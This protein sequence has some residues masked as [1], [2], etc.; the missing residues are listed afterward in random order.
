MRKSGRKLCRCGSFVM[1]V[2]LSAAMLLSL[3]GYASAETMSTVAEVAYERF[4]TS[5]ITAANAH[6]TTN[7]K[8]SVT[9]TAGKDDPVASMKFTPVKA[10]TAANALRVVIANRASCRVAAFDYVYKN[11]AQI[12][13]RGRVE[14]SLKQGEK[15]EEYIVH[16]PYVDSITEMNILFNDCARGGEIELIS[17]GAIS[18]FHDNREYA[19]TLSENIYDRSSKMAKFS[20]NVSYETILKYPPAK[21]V[22]YRLNQNETVEDVRFVHP[23]IQECPMTL[24]YSFSFQIN[25]T[26]EYCSRYFA[27]VLTEDNL[28][29]PL[30][31]ETYLKE[32]VKKSDDNADSE[33]VGFKG[34]E[35]T[36]YAGASEN[37]TAVAYVDVRLDLLNSDGDNGIQYVLDEG[38]EYYFDRDYVL[39]LDERIKSHCMAGATVYLRLL[40]GTNAPAFGH[41][42]RI[43]V[44]G[45]VKYFALNPVNDDTVDNIFAYTDFLASRYSSEDFGSLGGV[46]MGRSLDKSGKY[47]YCGSTSMADYA[48]MLAR[49]YSTIRHALNRSGSELEIFLPMSDSPIGVECLLSPASRENEYPADILSDSILAAL[50]RFGT[51]ISS[52]YFLIEGENVFDLPDDPSSAYVGIGEKDR[53]VNMVKDLSIKYK[54]LPDTLSFCWFPSISL[55]IDDMINKYMYNFNLLACAPYV[56]SYIVSIFER[57][58]MV[59]LRG[60]NQS[61]EQYIFWALK[62]TY[63][64]ADTYKN[65]VVSAPALEAIGG[66]RW[67][68]IVRNYSDYNVAKRTLSESPITYALPDKTKGSYKMWSFSDANG[69]GGWLASDGCSA[70]SVYTPSENIER[71]LI[72]EFDSAKGSLI[73]ADYASV[74]YVYPQYIEIRDISAIS[75]ELLIPGG[76]SEKASSGEMFELKITV[77]SGKETFESTG[78]IKSGEITTAYSDVSSLDRI[79]YIKIG[80]RSLSRGDDSK[81]LMCIRSVSL[82]SEVHDENELERMVLSGEMTPTDDPKGKDVRASLMIPAVV[83]GVSVAFI[84]AVWWASWAFRKKNNG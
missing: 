26:S 28:I 12:S 84:A 25:S 20:G 14:L 77:G 31:S 44:P 3:S 23:Y 35:T 62:N 66:T 11:T 19:G 80:I 52:L 6:I 74:I 29:I 46:I 73:G 9:L 8:G 50:G 53:F 7:E 61:A 47:N 13:E 15:P 24:E 5:E 37:G 76:S 82:H 81:G 34:M 36:L 57:E 54:G 72:A 10:E 67:E 63:N 69:T 33:R 48:D 41:L 17:M 2:V 56:R 4:C 68:N 42:E 32:E 45:G 59:D 78:V 43:L 70:L 18:Y 22:L 49:A 30:T 79:E 71:A 1:T 16:I 83:V 60:F 40:L 21:I 39:K 64:Y 65:P 58:E 55:G 75:F 38:K 51:D 27:A